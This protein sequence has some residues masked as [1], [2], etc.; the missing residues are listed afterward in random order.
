MP[1]KG[2]ID[3]SESFRHYLT[4]YDSLTHVLPGAMIDQSVRGPGMW[5][6]AQSTVFL[7]SFGTGLSG[8][9]SD[10][11]MPDVIAPANSSLAFAG[12][13]ATGGNFTATMGFNDAGTSATDVCAAIIYVTKIR[14]GVG[15]MTKSAV[16]TTS[17][18]GTISIAYVEPGA[19][20][21]DV[22]QVA[23]DVSDA[24]GNWLLNF[25]AGSYTCK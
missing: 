25:N 11:Y 23:V 4:S 5:K 15:V 13:V 8:Y 10:V 9:T 6:K 3:A 16:A 7:E 24:A 2:L 18:F 14:A 12:S 22:F 19:I 17:G 21:G 20:V 1:A